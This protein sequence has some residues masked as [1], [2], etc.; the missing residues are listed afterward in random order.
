M[1]ILSANF[2]KNFAK[3]LVQTNDDLWTLSHVIEPKD[4]ISGRTFRK[5]KKEENQEGKVKPVFLK[6]LVEKV[7]F[8]KYADTLRVLGNILEGPEDVPKLHHTFN[9]EIGSTITIE[10]EFGTYHINQLKQAADAAEK[11]DLTIIAVDSTNATFAELR[12]Y[13]VKFKGELNI[14]LPRKDDPNYEKRKDEFVDKLMK[15]VETLE[16]KII[17]AATGFSAE[18][19]RE[20][21]PEKLRKR[22]LF[23]KINSGGK[24]GIN[25]VLKTGVI[26][27]LVADSRASKE[28]Q[29]VEKLME[30]I[31]K[32]MATYG[33]DHVRKANDYGAVSILLVSDALVGEYKLAGRLNEID[34]IMRAVESNRGSV[35]VISDEHEAGKRLK[36][37]GGIAAILRFKI[38]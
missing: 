8:H 34:Q 28:S 26:D 35:N 27:K 1:K 29:L 9:I 37:L 3:I 38:E 10:K 20:A 16:N 30:A 5:I 36:A 32:D 6:M 12:Q 23:T 17:L 21:F 15:K 31:A 14:Q 4:V 25:E 33:M 22:I 13:G 19:L 2:R 18:N 11:V 24:S 7:E